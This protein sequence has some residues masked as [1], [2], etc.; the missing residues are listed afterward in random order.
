MELRRRRRPAGGAGGGASASASSTRASSSG[1]P[2]RFA[3]AKEQFEEAVEGRPEACADAHYWLG[4]AHRERRQ[5][6]RDAAPHFET[7]LKLAPTGPVRRAGE[8]HPRL[9]QEVARRCRIAD[10]LAAVRRP[11]CRG[12]A[13]AGR[14]PPPSASS[15]SRRRSAPSRPRGRRRRPARL[16]REPSPGSPAEDRGK[17]PNTDQVAPHRPP[18]VEQGARRR[19]RRSP[20]IHSIDSRRPAAKR[21]R[22]GGRG[23]ARPPDL[24]VQVDLAGEATKFGAAEA[25]GRRS[26]RA[27]RRA[28]GGAR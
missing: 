5:A 19:R 13:A 10:N 25:D 12:R 20:C 1:T 22:G 28:P 21:R 9:D 11:D 16:R 17:R 23:A 24:L 4:M 8:G 14:D 3:E 6:C 26:S 18:A 2:A 15:P 27:A 7:Y